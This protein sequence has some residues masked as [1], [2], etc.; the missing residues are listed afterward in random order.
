MQVLLGQGIADGNYRPPLG[1]A[2]PHLLIFRQALPQPVQPLGD[3]FTREACHRVKAGVHLNPGHDTLIRQV[4]REGFA[5]GCCLAQGLVVHDHPADELLQ[6]GGGEHHD[7]VSAPCFGGV[8]NIKF[9][10][11]VFCAAGALIS[12]QDAPAWRHHRFGG[13]H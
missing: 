11:A 1:K 9:L 5:V 7:A 2:R 8:G 6:P 4:L 13:F 3:K 10:E 12:S